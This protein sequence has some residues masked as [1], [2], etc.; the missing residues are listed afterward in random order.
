MRQVASRVEAPSSQRL[1]IWVLARG[2]GERGTRIVFTG[3]LDYAPNAD[4]AN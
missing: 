4:A 3:V 2:G 1:R